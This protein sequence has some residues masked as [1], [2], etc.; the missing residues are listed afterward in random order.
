MVEP[1][2]LWISIYLSCSSE[3]WAN[4][5]LFCI[6]SSCFSIWGQQIWQEWI[7]F[8]R[9][10]VEGCTDWFI[11]FPPNSSNLWHFLRII[12]SQAFLCNTISVTFVTNR[13]RLW[14]DPK[15]VWLRLLPCHLHPLIVYRGTLRLR[16]VKRLFKGH[17]ASYCLNKY[18]F[19]ICRIGGFTSGIV[20]YCK[21]LKRII[22]ETNQKIDS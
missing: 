4:S 16:V 10:H 19:W 5:C 1:V 15:D 21:S 3:A 8:P 18:L 17:T 22:R 6:A 12:W 11:K 9:Y 13:T 7:G 2:L 14:A 20:V